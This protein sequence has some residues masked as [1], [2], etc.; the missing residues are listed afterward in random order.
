ME[1]REWNSKKE[2]RQFLIFYRAVMCNYR[3]T[4]LSKDTLQL[5]SFYNLSYIIAKIINHKFIL[6]KR[7]IRSFLSA[8][9]IFKNLMVSIILTK[10]KIQL[11]RQPE[12]V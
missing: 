4:S 8:F 9:P 3:F 7:S 2:K 10:V 12:H 6:Y 5:S 1:N 11:N